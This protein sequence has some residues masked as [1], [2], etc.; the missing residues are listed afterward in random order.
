[1]LVDGL[2][3]KRE[4]YEWFAMAQMVADGGMHDGTIAMKRM[5]EDQEGLIDY[6]CEVLD[7]PRPRPRPFYEIVAGHVKS[8]ITKKLYPLKSDMSYQCIDPHLNLYLEVP[9]KHVL[10]KGNWV[11]Y[12]TD[13]ELRDIV[14]EHERSWF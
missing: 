7:I 8:K 1:M 5:P 6:L 13:K 11:K 14:S 10:V 9:T 4:L 12:D 3:S 2:I